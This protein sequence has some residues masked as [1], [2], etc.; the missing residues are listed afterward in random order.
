MVNVLAVMVTLQAL[1]LLF[2][3]LWVTKMEDR[4][5]DARPQTTTSPGG[6]D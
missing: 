1:F 4:T 2:T 3:V 5:E 6:N